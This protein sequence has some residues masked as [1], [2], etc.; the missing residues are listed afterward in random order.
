MA[1][2]FTFQKVTIGDLNNLPNNDFEPSQL[3][4]NVLDALLRSNECLCENGSHNLKV[5]HFSSFSV[6]FS[7]LLMK[8]YV[9]HIAHNGLQYRVFTIVLFSLSC[10]VK[11]NNKLRKLK[12]TSKLTTYQYSNKDIE[13]TANFKEEF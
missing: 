10:C 9:S 4:F 3:T 8:N 13:I 12:N 6:N 5:R 7:E 1:N 11:N 2:Y